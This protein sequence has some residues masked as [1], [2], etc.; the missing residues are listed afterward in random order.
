MYVLMF[1]EGRTALLVACWRGFLPIVIMLLKSCAKT[2]AQDQVHVLYGSVPSTIQFSAISLRV[3]G[4]PTS[5]NLMSIDVC[6]HD[7]CG[8]RRVLVV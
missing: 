2:N 5:H 8:H 1:Q 3:R 6:M 7:V 4:G